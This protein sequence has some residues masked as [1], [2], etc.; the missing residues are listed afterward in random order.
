MVG[1][2][3]EYNSLDSLNPFFRLVLGATA[4]SLLFGV[5]AFCMGALGRC[6]PA[7]WMG[8][9]AAMIGAPSVSAYCFVMTIFFKT[10]HILP[11]QFVVLGL[12]VAGP[13]AGIIGVILG[14]KRQSQ[15]LSGETQ[16]KVSP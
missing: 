5:T 3:A 10:G 7:V 4:L 1:I 2:L 8:A 11:R 9:I 6:R 13:P 16:R 14:C 15:T 12:F